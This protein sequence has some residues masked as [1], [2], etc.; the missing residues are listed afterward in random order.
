MT[1]EEPRSGLPI[2]FL[3]TIAAEAGPDSPPIRMAVERTR[4]LPEGHA[5][6]DLLLSLLLGALSGSAPDWMLKNAVDSDLGKGTQPH[7]GSSMTLAAAALAHPSCPDALRE[8]ALRRCSVTQL[9]VLGRERCGE[10]LA[11]AI[12]AELKRRGPHRQ[13]MTPELLERPSAAL[14]ILREPDLHDAVFSAA[15]D[16]LPEFPRLNRADES[17]EEDVLARY[18]RHRAARK[19]WETMWEHVVTLH[20]SRHRQLVEWAQDGHT[21]S[22]IRKHLLGTIPWD[23]EPSLL[24]EIATDDLGAFAVSDLITR[25]CRLLRDGVSEE[26]ARDRLA[27]EFEVLEPGVRQRIEDFFDDSIDVRKYGLQAAVS[28]A[29]SAADGSWRYILTPAEAKTRYGEPHTWR[30]SEELLAA[31]G[32]RFAATAVNAL[33]LWEPDPD[34][35]RPGP[36]DLRWIHAMLL[37][38]PYV[39]EEVK[40]K[41]RAVIRHVHPRSRSPW[42]HI[43]YTAQQDDRR[44]AELRTAIEGILGDPATASRGSALGE[45][46]Q[47]TVGKLA[48]ASDEVLHDYL[49]RHT[50]DDDLIEKLLLSFASRSYRSKLSFTDVLARHSA[51]ESALLRITADLRRRLGG[52]PNLREAWAR[53]VLALSDCA[54]ELILALPAWTALTVGGARYGTAHKIVTSVVLNALGND[55]EAWS[56]FATSP[57]SY[58]GPTAWLRLGDILD[59]AS[60]GTAWP[61]PP[62]AK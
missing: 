11:Q 21:T 49:A 5:R 26:E 34:P 1:T 16:L 30:A 55:D 4:E 19:A 27:D 10:P 24:E 42:E 61:K 35:G 25:L 15:L 22:V 9:G 44:L 7:P 33:R 45:P 62:N 50:G 18:D 57:A 48:D 58:A 36:R 6:D 43:G 54:P 14:L 17:G 2:E 46:R 13:P 56:R 20:T 28:W 3:R 23:V 41:A 8:E 31:L 32:Q 53:Q 59:A 60:K 38:L 47:V 52:G 12:V 37:H 39:T 51:P 40:E 29:E